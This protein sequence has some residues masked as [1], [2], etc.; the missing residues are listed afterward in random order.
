MIQGNVSIE[1]HYVSYNP[2]TNVNK[3]NVYVNLNDN[4]VCHSNN[5][6]DLG[7]TKPNDC[8]LDV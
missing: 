3:C 5:V 6:F 4:K 8:I 2:F 7:M 1:F